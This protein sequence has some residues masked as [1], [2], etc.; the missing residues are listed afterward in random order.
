MIFNYFIVVDA[1]SAW[2]G[3]CVAIV[4]TFKKIKNENGDDLLNFAV[5]CFLNVFFGLKMLAA[6]FLFL[7]AWEDLEL[8]LSCQPVK[9]SSL[10]II[11]CNIFYC[12]FEKACT[13]LDQCAGFCFFLLYF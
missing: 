8:F 12:M 2:C 11:I 10:K 4:N 1:Y 7:S 5:V 6:F 13:L 9:K 3:P